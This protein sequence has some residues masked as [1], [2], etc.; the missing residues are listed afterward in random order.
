MAS[1]GRSLHPRSL[2]VAAGV[3]AL[4][5]IV[6][7]WSLHAQRQVRLHDAN[8]G[9]VEATPI[10]GA[11][12][13]ESNTQPMMTVSLRNRSGESLTVVIERGL[14]LD[15]EDT[16]YPD[17]VVGKEQLVTLQP[18]EERDVK[19]YAFSLDPAYR[20]VGC[21]HYYPTN[22]VTYSVGE[23]TDSSELLALLERIDRNS[24]HGKYE[25]QIAIWM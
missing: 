2:H 5:A 4:L 1:P 9:E 18:G 6:A 20:E 16:A 11:N 19:L 12:E 17:V 7:P 10:A 14:V 22:S 8:L 21:K 3:L 24:W 13:V 23:M 15:S 25:A